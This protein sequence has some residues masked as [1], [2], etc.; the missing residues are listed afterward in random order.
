MEEEE[1]EEAEKEDEEIKEVEDEEMSVVLMIKL[2]SL[3]D[4]HGSPFE[5]DNGVDD[6]LAGCLP[7]LTWVPLFCPERMSGIIFDTWCRGATVG[8]L[9][10]AS[11]A[12][13]PRSAPFIFYELRVNDR[14]HSTQP[15][16]V[17]LAPSRLWLACAWNERHPP[18]THRSPVVLPT[19]INLTAWD[20]IVFTVHTCVQRNHDRPPLHFKPHLVLLTVASSGSVQRCLAYDRTASGVTEEGLIR[21]H[22]SD[23]CKNTCQI[24]KGCS[25]FGSNCLCADPD[26]LALSVNGEVHMPSSDDCSRNKQTGGVQFPSCQL[27]GK[28]DLLSFKGSGNLR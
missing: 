13:L 23:V 11:L 22:W 20:P 18:R 12:V 26:V 16:A 28:D 8:T 9:T 3:D 10:G 17:H 4:P 15:H 19:I 27:G 21:V 25:N 6:D 14:T 1:E 24:K 7:Q 2:R 5:V